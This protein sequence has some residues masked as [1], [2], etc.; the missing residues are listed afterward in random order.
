L[1][2]K[3]EIVKKT[4]LNLIL[5]AAVLCGVVVVAQTQK[6]VE[7]INPQRHGNLAAAQRLCEKA[8][9]KVVAAQQA[10]EYDLAGHA[11]KAKEL[12]EEANAELKQAAETA[13]QNHK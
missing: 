10:N 2:H 13:N 12:L 4:I 7:N 11:K 1:F 8:Y 6:P 9:E 5:G 3:E